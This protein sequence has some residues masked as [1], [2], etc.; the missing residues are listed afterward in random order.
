MISSTLTAPAGIGVDLS[1][2]ERLRKCET[3]LSAFQAVN[4]CNGLTKNS[5]RKNNTGE[6][7]KDLLR[8]LGVFIW[9]CGKR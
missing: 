5:Q 4:E 7:A 2:E 1:R 6:M 3:C 8:K 9:E